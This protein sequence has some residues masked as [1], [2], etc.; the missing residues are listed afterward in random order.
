MSRKNATS[1]TEQ[2]PQKETTETELFTEDQ[3]R[4]LLRHLAEKDGSMAELAGRLG[5]SGQLIG[6]V[7][8]GQRAPGKKL[9]EAFSG[10]IVVKKM[11]ELPIIKEEANGESGTRADIQ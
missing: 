4:A 5:V 3:F 1:K 2:L 9:V 8:A 10:R 11:I 7:I 6:Y